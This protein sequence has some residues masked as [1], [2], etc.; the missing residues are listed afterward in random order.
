[1]SPHSQVIDWV[2][3]EE[4]I[5]LTQSDTEENFPVDVVEAQE[6]SDTEDNF[7][8]D[9]GEA[10]EVSDTEDNFHVDAEE[11]QSDSDT[12]I[13]TDTENISEEM[14]ENDVDTEPWEDHVQREQDSD[15]NLCHC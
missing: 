14:D 5:D 10:Q 6:V 13:L 7:P 11:A 15:S 8:V 2:D 9:D 4:I 12:V 3:H 1:M